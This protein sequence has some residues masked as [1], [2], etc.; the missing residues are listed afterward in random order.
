MV[1]S[2]AVLL[3]IDLE[4][5]PKLA[6]ITVNAQQVIS[7]S[8]AD[9]WPGIHTKLLAQ[10]VWEAPEGACSTLANRCTCCNK[11]NFSMFKRPSKQASPVC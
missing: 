2:I 5:A 4:I 8:T 11:N 1:K 9:T 3:K 7:M 10:T 6:L